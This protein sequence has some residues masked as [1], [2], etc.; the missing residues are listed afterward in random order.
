MG[1]LGGEYNSNPNINTPYKG[2]TNIISHNQASS[3]CDDTSQIV[4]SNDHEDINKSRTETTEIVNI[5]T[6]DDCSIMIKIGE[7][8]H[9][10]LWDSVAGKCV[11]SLD[12][13]KTIPEKLKTQLFPSKILIKAANGSR[14]E[15]NGECDITFKIRPKKFTFSFLVSNALT[16]DVIL[17]HNFSR[18][19]HIG[20]DW[21]VNDEMYL[22]MNG[23]LLTTT[24]NTKAINALVQCV[25]ALVIPPK[26][27]AMIKCRAPKVMC[28]QNFERICIFEPS[29][30]HKADYTDC[31]TYN[32]TVVMDDS[33]K[34][35]GIFEIV[36][37]NNS[38]KT[39]K[40]RRNTTMGLLKS[41]VED[42]I[43]TI[44][45]VITFDKPND[46][47]KPK[48]I[49]KNMYAIPT[50]NKSRKVK[51]NTLIPKE[52][53][54]GIGIHEIGPQDD[55]VKYEKPKLQDAPVDI[56]ILAD[57]EKLFEENKNA[58]AHNET[59]IGTTPLITMSIDTGDH[60]PIAK[61]PYTLALKHYEWA[62]KEIDKLLKAGV[63]RESHSSWSAPVVIVPKSNG[64]KRLFVD[65]RALNKITRTYIWP[66]P[67]AEDIFAKLGKAKFF[68][69]LDLRSRYHHIALDEDAIKKTGFCLPFGKYEYLK[70]PFGLVQAPA[71][72]QNLMNKVLK[73]LKFAFAYLDDII[74]FSE[75][76]EEHL[77]HIKIVLKRLQEANLKMKR[78]KCS[79][80]QKGV[81]LPWSLVNYNRYQASA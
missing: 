35:S 50:R 29:N 16:Q 68:T 63:I 62:R 24:I 3:N 30:R 55:F 39:V 54:P 52:N 73:G 37:T 59:E 41:C 21:N 70:V 33:V 46:G 38:W 17:G 8:S 51:V 74:I 10:A 14:I 19:Y 23:Q 22:K 7:R 32:G 76:A 1:K 77:T 47:V 58:F 31:H 28:Q 43:C 11:I 34:C 25:E 15:N 81:A 53:H 6:K 67:R 4:N 2:N 26:C 20:T 64:E 12:K 69:T 79:F 75:T 13:Y 36:M 44:H 9:K 65:F 71:Y 5:G 78:S 66:M 27:N 40:I 18:A 57:L 45:R 48:I 49:E 61:R 60:E 72:F 80:F 56:N 42:E